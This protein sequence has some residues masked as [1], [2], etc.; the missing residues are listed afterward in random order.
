MACFGWSELEMSIAR[1]KL[2]I[3]L[4]DMVGAMCKHLNDKHC[5]GIRIPDEWSLGRR[6]C[7]GYFDLFFRAQ[8]HANDL[9]L[10]QG[11]ENFF[12][13]YSI[14]HPLMDH[15]LSTVRDVCR[16]TEKE[17]LAIKGIGRKKLEWIKGR[18]S[19]HGLRLLTEKQAEKRGSRLL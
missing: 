18:L 12:V 17:L 10:K 14:A 19:Q 9:V 2:L 6:P 16:K 7:P 11:L 1:D 13:D 8:H 3:D 15:G 4:F 5:A